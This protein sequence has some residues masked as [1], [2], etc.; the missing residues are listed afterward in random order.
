MPKDKSKKEEV[1]IDIFKSRLVPKCKIL[2]EEERKEFLEKYN[3]SKY[4]LPFIFS[5]DPM[6][7]AVDGKKG[8]ILKIERKVGTAAGVSDY[9]RLVVGGSN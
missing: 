4:Q 8:D 2:N 3:I 5:N 9:F 7:R 1:L 6:V